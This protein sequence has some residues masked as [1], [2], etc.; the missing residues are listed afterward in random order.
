MADPTKLVSTRIGL[1]PNQ[2]TADDGRYF[3]PQG[4]KYEAQVATL[5]QDLRD[6]LKQYKGEVDAIHEEGRKHTNGYTSFIHRSQNILSG[7]ATSSKTAKVVGVALGVAVLWEL[8]LGG[9]WLLKKLTNQQAREMGFDVSQRYRR[10][11][12][13]RDWEIRPDGDS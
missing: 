6:Q 5:Q 1:E 3:T 8:Y 12:H 13:S 7:F 11:S 10:R 2:L 9:K 4:A